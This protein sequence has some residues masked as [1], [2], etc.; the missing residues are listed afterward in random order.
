MASST[1]SGWDALEA[2]VDELIDL[3]N[4]LLRE[5]QA[6]RLQ[7]QNWTTERAALIEKN[8]LAKSRVE[9]M[10]GRLKGLEQD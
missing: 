3:N 9:A 4:K 1:E 2:R 10:I 6:L 8:E 5:N 7:Q